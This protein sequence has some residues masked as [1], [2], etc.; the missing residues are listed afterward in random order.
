MQIPD[1]VLTKL[2]MSGPPPSFLMPGSQS[3]VPGPGPQLK[4]AFGQLIMPQ[5]GPM[6]PMMNMMPGA[7]PAPQQSRQGYQM[8]GGIGQA[9]MGG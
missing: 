4:N 7:A 1:D 2:A 5:Q 9:L 6:P 3:L 8:Q